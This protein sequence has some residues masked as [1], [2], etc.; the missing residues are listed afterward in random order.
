MLI[1]TP[2]ASD[3]N[4]YVTLDEAI[5]YFSNRMYADVWEAIEDQENALI[6]A[7][8][9]ID[10]YITWKGVRV[11]GTQSLDWPRSGVYDKVG[12]LYSE[13]IIPADVKVAVFEYVLSSASVDRTADGALAGLSEVKAGSLQ[14]KTDDGIY[15][16]TP[17]TIPDKIW[18]ILSGLTTKGGAGV[19]WLLRA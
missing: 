15:N 7:T 18:K 16:T 17:D 2:G 11:N 4:S 3:A 8:S 19:V 12:V 5:E 1:A 6:T 10:W 9:V 14:L 13:I